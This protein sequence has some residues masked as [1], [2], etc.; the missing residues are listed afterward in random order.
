MAGREMIVISIGEARR[1]K[2]VQSAIDGHT[3]QKGAAMMLGQSERQVRR[4]L[5]AVRDKGARGIMDHGGGL[6]IGNCPLRSG[7]GCYHFI[8]GDILI[9][10]PPLR[11]RSF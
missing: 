11:R 1:L 8:V 10:V 2:V 7:S 6:R 3:S 5:K 4:L 9:L